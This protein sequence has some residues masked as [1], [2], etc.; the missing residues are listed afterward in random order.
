MTAPRRP[1]RDPELDSAL[2]VLLPREP[3]L[4]TLSALA[5]ARRATLAATSTAQELSNKW[6]LTVEDV[7]YSAEASAIASIFGRSGAQGRARPVFL[8]LHGGGLVMGNRFTGVEAA[9]GWVEAFDAV[10][11]SVEYRLAPEHRFPA[12]VEDAWAALQWLRGVG[13]DLNA[14]PS[15]IFVAGT[16]AG[17][18]LAAHVAIRA[19]DLGVPLAGQILYCPMLDARNDSSSAHQFAELGPWSA[20]DNETAWTATLGPDRRRPDRVRD[21][22]PLLADDLGGLAPA[23]LDVGSAEVFRDEVVEYARRIWAAGGEAELHVWPGG[24]HGFTRKVPRAAIS[25][26]SAR[27]RLD[28]IERRLS[29]G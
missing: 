23:F 26:N 4:P 7:Q 9:L 3:S 25:R 22:S 6:G 24:F 10:V 20:L 12:A 2:S 1:A 18:G 8:Y 19:R 27:V 28:W 16:S 5:D 14:D 15:R 17:G 13:A 21:A 11:V 29:Y